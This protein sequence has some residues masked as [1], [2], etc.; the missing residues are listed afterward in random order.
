MFADI[1]PVYDRMNGVMSLRL[2]HRWRKFAV[3]QL[4][5]QEGDTGLDLCSGTGD[6]LKP[7]RDA[8]G[9]SG[10]IMGIDFCK[11]MLNFC[12][13]KIGNDRNST[14]LAVGDACRI[15]LASHS[16]DAVTVGWGMRNVADLDS[17]HQEIFRILKSNGRFV[18]L[19]CAIPKN[20]MIRSVSMFVN[21]FVL[22][23]MG[24]VLGNGIAYTYLPESV[25]KFGTRDEIC[26]QMSQ[27]GFQEVTWT[28]L[29]FGNICLFQGVKP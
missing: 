16:V 5:V 13:P 6:F 25:R 27:A 22:P 7:L 26:R 4:H 24:R 17:A 10:H 21:R 11:P 19:E 28:D 8:V 3:H 15:P 1:A 12:Q 2:H 18:S 9:K 29:F 23:T 20:P 14:L